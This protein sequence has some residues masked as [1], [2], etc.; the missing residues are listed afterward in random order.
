MG[1]RSHAIE[2]M[3][4]LIV[5]NIT[6]FSS[7]I[8]SRNTDFYLPPPLTA[9][10][11]THMFTPTVCGHQARAVDSPEYQSLRP[12]GAPGVVRVLEL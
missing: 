3:V 6:D 8:N 7:V 12:N 10:M 4:I 11:P 5:A 9:A 2:E 1:F